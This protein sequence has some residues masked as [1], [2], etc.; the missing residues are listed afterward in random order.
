LENAQNTD[1]LVTSKNLKRRMLMSSLNKKVKAAYTEENCVGTPVKKISA[2]AQLTRLTLAHMLFED[3]FYVDGVSSA[4]ALQKAIKAAKPAF[5]VKLAKKARKQFKLRHVP[6]LLVRELLRKG[7]IKADD[8]AE[9]IQRPDE[10]GELLAIYNKDGRKPLAAQLKKG[11][12]KAF[13]KFNEYSLAKNDKNSAAYS[14]RDVM[15]M[16]RPKPVDDVQAALFKRIAE[17]KMATPDT[18]ETEL[19][20]G[21]GKKET[22]ERLMAEKQLH[23]LAFLRNLRN[24]TEAGIPENKIREYAKRLDVKNV[25]PFRYIA[26]A[27]IVPQFEDMLEEMMFRSVEHIEKIPGRTVLVVDVSGSMRSRV[28]GKSEIERLDAAAALAILAREMCEEVVIYATAGSDARRTHKTAKVAPRRG[29]ALAEAIRKKAYSELGGGG[30]FL[31][32]CMD[33]IAEEEKANKA[34][35][36]IVFTDEQDTGGRGFEPD[37]AKRIGK[38]NYIFNVGSYQNGV[39]SGA[40]ETVTGFSEAVFDYLKEFEKLA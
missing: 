14:V 8:I 34:D 36:V 3:Q 39:N 17:G 9:V 23:A 35:R 18:W 10:M 19:S 28:S 5:A 37:R 29:F 20:A 32:Q 40:W 33:Y 27:R 30:I 26:A 16:V 21:K 25:L 1:S 2:E 6:L 31:I 11:L 13:L 4:E 15:F 22:F 24:M 12:A 7:N 38:R